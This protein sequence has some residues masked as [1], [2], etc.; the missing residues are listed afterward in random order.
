[1]SGCCWASMHAAVGGLR[2]WLCGPVTL[3]PPA[4]VWVVVGA[5]V[6]VRWDGGVPPCSLVEGWLCQAVHDAVPS[7]ATV[8][9]AP[10]R[11]NS[12]CDLKTWACSPHQGGGPWPDRSSG[13][14]PL[15]TQQMVTWSSCIHIL[16]TPSCLKPA[17]SP[18]AHYYRVRVI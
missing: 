15:L 4:W 5:I 6:V 3:L 13:I 2:Q 11:P 1:M 8:P 14:G 16:A 17:P 9:M 10:P 12:K 18:Q 7:T